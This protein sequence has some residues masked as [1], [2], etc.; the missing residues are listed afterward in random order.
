MPLAKGH[1]VCHEL[2]NAMK[3]IKLVLF[4]LDNTLAF[5]EEAEAFYRQYPRVL[6][7]TLARQLSISE[8]S[9]KEI[10]DKF[11]ADF[12]GRGELAFEALGLGLES[13]Y[14]AICELEPRKYLRPIPQTK[15]TLDAIRNGGMQIGLVTNGP[16][17]QARRILEQI[18]V[19][20]DAFAF[21][22]GWKK[23][24][25]F[26]KEESGRIF[27]SIAER[28]GIMPREIVMVG[29]SLESDI[30]PAER[31]G[32]RTVH[33]TNAP[34]S[35]TTERPTIRSVEQLLELNIL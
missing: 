34:G 26:P 10:A 23:G 2:N 17:P 25:S 11:R 32:L 24:E 4:D 13:W 16:T 27:L 8:S 12:S 5:G 35:N 28:S 31:V 14:E 29:D 20:T 1:F 9:A 3:N 6:E 30:L 15:R 33:I 22:V 19:D 18:G 21:F 7:C